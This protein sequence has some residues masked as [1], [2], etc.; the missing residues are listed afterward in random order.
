M[1]GNR[2]HIM[3]KRQL[4][5]FKQKGYSNSKLAT[6]LKI[7]RKT[8]N[9]YVKFLGDLGFSY[10]DLLSM[11]ESNLKDLFPHSDTKDKDCYQM[12]GI[13]SEYKISEDEPESYSQ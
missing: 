9:E 10:E 13:Q 5:Q 7:G 11:D 3:D 1:A 2:K 8:V 6:Y 12:V 4:L